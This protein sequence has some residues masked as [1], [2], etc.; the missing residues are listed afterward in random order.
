V[1]RESDDRQRGRATGAD[2]GVGA[3]NWLL[4]VCGV[5]LLLFFLLNLQ[6]V[7]VHLLIATVD[8][9]LIVALVIAAVLGLALGWAVP[10]L[11][12]SNRT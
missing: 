9:P 1:R 12:G 11:R 2:S 3:K 8:M 5:L 4:I 10:R 7:K 6:K